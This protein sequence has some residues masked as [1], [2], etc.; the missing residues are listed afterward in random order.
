MPK[1]FQTIIKNIRPLV[2]GLSGGRLYAI[3]DS[4]RNQNIY[5]VLDPKRKRDQ[6]Y[7]FEK[8]DPEKWFPDLPWFKNYRKCIYPRKELPEV[9]LKSSPYLVEINLNEKFANW[10]FREGWGDNWGIYF[11]S[12]ADQ[13]DLYQYFKSL[14]LMEDECG[15]ELY[16]RYYD[17]RVF[18]SY[19]PTCTPVELE[20]LFEFAERFLVEQDGGDQINLYLSD[21]GVLRREYIDLT[22]TKI[23]KETSA[24]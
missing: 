1:N 19:I 7:I 17:P 2:E 12:N 24:R 21:N 4:A 18:R 15:K 10:L 14:L 5:N 13:E 20:T 8:I 11:I 3:L 6:A 23:N 16:F 22:K 9:L